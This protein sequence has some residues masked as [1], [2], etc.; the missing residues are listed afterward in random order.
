MHVGVDW[1]VVQV[2]KRERGGDDAGRRTCRASEHDVLERKTSAAIKT[3]SE[4]IFPFAFMASMGPSTGPFA[5]VT[6]L[7]SEAYL[8]GALTLAGALRDLHPSPAV[9]PE[10]DFQTVCLVTP[11]SVDVSAI[12]LLRR[13]FDVVV[14]VEII[15]QEDEKGLKLLGRLD[16]NT[17]LTKLHVFRL[18]QYSKIIFLDA[19]VLPVRPLSHLFTLPYEFSAVPDVGWPDI[20]NSGVL[21]LSPGEEKFNDLNDLLKSKGTWDGGDQGILNEWRGG[22]WHRLSFTY[23]TTPT[24]AYTYAPAYERFGSQISAIHFIG[25][26][27]PWKS[28]P[29]RQPFQNTTSQSD[30]GPLQAYDYTTLVDRWFAVY[31]KHCRTGSASSQADFEVKRYVSAWDEQIGTGSEL[32]SGSIASGTALG[33]EDLKKMAIHGISAT[34]PTRPQSSVDGDYI[35][36]PLE[37]RIDLMRP[38][39][40]RPPQSPDSVESNDTPTPR[41]RSP[42]RFET[43]P[44]PGPDEIPPS[45]RIPTISLPP[46]PSPSFFVPRQDDPSQP[47]FVQH[48]PSSPAQALQQQLQNNLQGQPQHSQE[49]PRPQTDQHLQHN[50]QQQQQ[51]Q[52]QYQE[53][54]HHQEH[55]QQRRQEPPRPPSPPMMLWNPASEPPPTTQPPSSAFPTD[56]Y[57]PNVWDQ[58][59]HQGYKQGPRPASPPPPSNIF[60]QAPPP[61]EIPESLLRQGHYEQV[62]GHASP[63]SEGHKLSNTGPDR[64]KVKSIFPWEEKP[65]QMPGRVF[66]V[67]DAPSPSEFIQA[68]PS[69]PEPVVTPRQQLL[70]PLGGLPVTLAYANAWDTVPSIQRYASRL[71]RPHASPVALMPSFDDERYRR[72]RRSRDE[73]TEESSMDGDDEDD[74]DDESHSGVSESDRETTATSATGGSS[75]S[76]TYSYKRK[77][78]E[79]TVRGVQTVSPEYRS[80]GTQVTSQ[81]PKVPSTTIPTSRE[82]RLSRLSQDG[83]RAGTSSPVAVRS[84]GLD[85]SPMTASPTSMVPPPLTSPRE[86]ASITPPTFIRPSASPIQN[87]SVSSNSTQDSSLASPPSSTGPVSP[88]DGVG[89]GLPAR[90][91]SRVWDPARGVELFKR[92]SEEVLARFLKMGSWEEGQ[93]Q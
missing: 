69:T 72:G 66:P 6:L 43:L 80:Q 46:T 67:E 62:I 22:D 30:S 39:K 44:T 33:L 52:Q 86:F 16:L 5:F 74:G 17:V 28:L 88:P 57:F 29:F 65:R 58:P 81:P 21:V 12:K 11:E 7:T 1:E 53:A 64:S 36:L 70:S 63:S 54:H 23:N 10:V 59:S 19:D 89:A 42:P 32:I 92:G 75:I 61:S 48:Q 55:Q 27:K 85:L 82:R 77:K 49:Q 3:K 9:S 47:T 24:A 8:P 35:A 87:Q 38:Q 71:V 56:T 4:V 37:G 79:Y 13:A 73:R 34:P 40:Q 93:Q 45:P 50:G 68:N 51:Q 91:G 41:A 78:K 76:G 2:V 83:R 90:K 60:F 26:N 31:D 84:S 18:T 25:P 14:G 20:F 15:G